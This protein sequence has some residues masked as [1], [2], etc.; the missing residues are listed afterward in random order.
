MNATKRYEKKK[1]KCVD[2]YL[3]RLVTETYFDR[4]VKSRK[5]REGTEERLKK[6]E[7]ELTGKYKK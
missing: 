2:Y 5:E 7:E 1:R 3:L 4:I 6:H